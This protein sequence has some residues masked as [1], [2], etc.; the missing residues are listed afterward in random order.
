M[1]LAVISGSLFLF[2]TRP[3]I[4]RD[5]TKILKINGVEVRVEVADTQETRE[6]GLSD[7]EVLQTDTGM[8][9][10]FDKP[11]RHGFWMKDMNFAIDI[12][13][14]DEKSQV[15]GLERDVSPETFPQVF[16]PDRAVKYVLEIPAGTARRYRIDSGT[17]IQ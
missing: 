12:V 5:E 15:V 8:L 3:I 14:I 2:L 6:I 13:W 17:V 4:P 10:I 16:Y 7:R 1:G 9:F 11:G